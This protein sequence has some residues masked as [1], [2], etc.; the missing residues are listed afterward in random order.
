MLNFENFL[1][2]VIVGDYDINLVIVV[3]W[4]MRLFCVV[5]RHMCLV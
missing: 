3:L 4:V 1:V 2:L 5:I